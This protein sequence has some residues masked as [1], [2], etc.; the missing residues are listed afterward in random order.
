LKNTAAFPG[1]RSR[2]DG[3]L[4]RLAV[5]LLLVV[6]VWLLAARTLFAQEPDVRRLT[7]QDALELARQNNPTFLSQAN[8]Q[9]PADWG[10]R[11]AYLSFLP[12]VNASA[13][14]TYTRPGVQ[15][16][17]TQVSEALGTDYLSTRYSIGFGW[18]LN[19]N[20]L[21]G[22][23]SARASS[24]ATAAR[25]DAARFDLESRVTAQY[26]TALRARDALEV[27]QRGQQ[28][29]ARNL[30]LVRTR[31]SVG[32]SAGWEGKQAEVELGRAEVAVLQ[33]ER[34][35]R[36]EKLRLVEQLGEPLEGDFELTSE[37]S[38]FEPS[39]TREELL[40]RALAAH[41][42][43]RS[44]AAQEN[45]AR[46][47]LRQA[48]SQYFPSVS[49]FTG[50]GGNAL[51]ARNQDYLAQ[52]V[53]T[54]ETNRQRSYDNCIAAQTAWRD[55]ERQL[56]VTFPATPTNCGS[57]LLSD[58]DRAQILAAGDVSPFGGPYTKNP[59]SVGMSVS[60]PLFNNFSRE[61]QV[62]QAEAA[63]EDA[64]NQHRAEEL[65]LRTSVAESLDGLQV[66]Y[67]VVTI[68]E[69]NR[70]V[71][72]ERLALASQRYAI[73]AAGIIEL[74]DAETSMS[75]AE[76]GYL[77]AVYQFHQALVALEAATGLSLRAAANP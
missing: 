37:F 7:L 13:G 49:L 72:T 27:A 19:G 32:A 15:R 39:W 47:S 76:G 46:A 77:N 28:R 56:G 5:G 63:L 55:V 41:P 68:E 6:L 69:R 24:V 4:A 23:P 53:R 58:A 70:E 11:E 2:R 38:V 25:I 73:G 16:I 57:P 42:G 30:E 1:T 18:T 43:L 64:R 75:T 8:D 45:A 34:A 65:R 36:A 3:E 31:V 17:G 20:V 33:A 10:V 9:G 74:M 66:A 71:A 35:L 62:S 14:A 21:F 52:Q 59:F 60:I 12:D 61:R 44:Q 67:R 29:A 54:Q 50:I 48:R 40:E 22:L 51:Q 26:M